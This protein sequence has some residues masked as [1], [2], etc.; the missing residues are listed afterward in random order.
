M[1][2]ES[3]QQA[4]ASN[5]DV[6]RNLIANR[7]REIADATEPVWKDAPVD[8]SITNSLPNAPLGPEQML[9]LFRRH[10]HMVGGLGPCLSLARPATLTDCS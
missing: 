2:R 4:L 8:V 5:A 7:G 1:D 10:S 3:G 9:L 6:W